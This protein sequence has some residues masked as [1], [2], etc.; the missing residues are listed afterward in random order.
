MIELILE[1]NGMQEF[2]FKGTLEKATT[3]FYRL[4]VDIKQLGF[5]L[6]CD[7]KEGYFKIFV[8]D[9]RIIRYAEFSHNDKTITITLTE[10]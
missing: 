5:S 1:F 6:V 4:F 8:P 7:F 9:E 2:Y 10:N 3:V